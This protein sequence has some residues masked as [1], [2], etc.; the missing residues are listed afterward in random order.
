M[1][2]KIL[3]GLCCLLFVLIACQ[4]TGNVMPTPKMVETKDVSTA[5]PVPTLVIPTATGIPLP[6]VNISTPTEIP[7]AGIA[8]DYS[9]S[10]YLDDRSTPASMVLSYANALSRHEFLRAYGYWI[11]P[12]TY[13][14]TLDNFSNYYANISSVQLVFG[15]ITSEGAAG[16]IY[17]TVPAVLKFTKMDSSID[18]YAACFLARLAQPGNYG[19]PPI[20]PMNFERG[21]TVLAPP[22]TSDTDGLSSACSS[23]DYS[24]NGLPGSPASTES[25]SDLSTANYV[26]NRSGAVEVVS[27]LINAINRKEYVRAYSYWENAIVTLG[28]YDAYAA[29]FSD[30]QSI[31]ATFGTVQ[32]DAGAGQWH[33]LIPVA[34]VVQTTSA[35]TTTYVG[36]Y[37]LH[38]SNPAI[39][40]SLPFVPLGISNGHFSLVA[41]GSNLVPLLAAAC[42]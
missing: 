39:Q 28:N 6:T 8:V 4:L 13:L 38:I 35:T 15:S 31:T 10:V 21:I 11:D 24:T 36:C 22:S 16:S 3:Y 37:T 12:A 41:N 7:A 23:P 29:G 25:L 14:G 26:D 1:N 2:K 5:A 27:S 34:E 18:K 19:A 42:N 20:T 33:Y 9:A 30:T 17:S 40:G 32:S